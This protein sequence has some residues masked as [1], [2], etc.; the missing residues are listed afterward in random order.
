MMQDDFRPSRG[1]SE[2]TEITCAEC[3]KQDTVPFKPR[4]GSAVY[5]RDCFAKRRPARGGPRR[6]G[7]GR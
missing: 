2:P 5:C 6:G 3:G 1:F 7:F 4:E